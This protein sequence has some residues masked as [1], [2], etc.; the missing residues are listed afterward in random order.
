MYN[1]SRAKASSGNNEIDRNL[2]EIS[3]DCLGLRLRKLD[4]IVTQIYEKR[5]APHDISLAQFT[6]LTV[7][8]RLKEPSPAQLGVFFKLR[9]PRSPEISSC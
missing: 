5:L 2:L 1:S 9:S 4:R 6:L 8:G 7:I 3:R